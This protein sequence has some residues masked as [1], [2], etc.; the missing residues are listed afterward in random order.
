MFYNKKAGFYLGV[1][2]IAPKPRLCPQMWVTWN[3]VW[4]TQSIGTL[5]QKGAFGWHQNTPECISGSDS[6]LG[7]GMDTDLVVGVLP[8]IFCVNRP[9]RT[10]VIITKFMVSLRH[11]HCVCVNIKITYNMSALCLRSI[12]IYC[13]SQEHYFFKHDLACRAVSL[14]VSRLHLVAVKSMHLVINARPQTE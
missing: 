13:N 7:W 5:V 9:C 8:R 6:L 12:F 1:W 4:R 11:C 2:E 10:T 3:T 14:L